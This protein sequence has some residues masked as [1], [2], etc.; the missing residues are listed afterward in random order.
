MLNAKFEIVFYVLDTFN[1]FLENK[2][3][4]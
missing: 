4:I 3:S 2:S 1:D